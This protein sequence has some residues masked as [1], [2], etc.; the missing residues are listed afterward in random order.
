MF[1]RPSRVNDPSR[2]GQ[3]FANG[4]FILI[5]RDAY[6]SIGGHEAVRADFCEDIHLGRN[7]KDA[8][9]GVR[10]ATAPDLAAVRMYATVKSFVSGWSRIFYSLVDM[11]AKPLWGMA[12]LLAVFSL[13][14]YAVMLTGGIALS[15]GSTSVFVRALLVL[16]VVH[17][18]I[19]WTLYVRLYAIPGTSLRW[20]PLRVFGVV[21][22]LYVLFRTIQTCRT[23]VVNWR[24]TVYTAALRNGDAR[25]R[26]AA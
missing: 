9:I 4:Q 12:T 10:V 14:P 25:N 11:R 24:G 3:G 5:Q 16:A 6:R 22:M 18:L 20:L 2:K 13:L 8:G 23:H 21:A 1:Y 15:C 17:E 26:A 19:Q 7:A